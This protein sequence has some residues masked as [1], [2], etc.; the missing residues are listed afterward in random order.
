MGLEV[1]TD[2]VNSPPHYTFGGIETIKYIEAKLTRDQYI[3]YLRGNIIKYVS[4]LGLKDEDVTD[5]GKIVW[6][7][8]ELRRVL[9]NG[10]L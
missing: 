4:R 8:T 10:N 1:V 5:I 3:G 7:S 9:N 6:Y 2:K